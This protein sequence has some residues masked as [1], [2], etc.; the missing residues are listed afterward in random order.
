MET[1]FSGKFIKS[2]KQLSMSR[3]AIRDHAPWIRPLIDIFHR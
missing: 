3:D 2:L 1:P